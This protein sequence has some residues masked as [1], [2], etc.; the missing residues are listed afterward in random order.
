MRTAVLGT[1]IEHASKLLARI[2][3]ADIRTQ[4]NRLKKHNLPGDVRHVAQANLRD[5]VRRS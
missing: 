2:Q 4:E 3:S 5:L 1:L